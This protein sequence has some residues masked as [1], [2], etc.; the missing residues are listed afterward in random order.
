MRHGGLAAG[1]TGHR[2][3]FRGPPRCLGYGVLL[4]QHGPHLPDAGPGRVQLATDDDEM[5]AEFLKVLLEPLLLELRWMPR[6]LELL[7]LELI[8]LTLGFRDATPELL[9]VARQ[10]VTLVVQLTEAGGQ[11]VDSPGQFLR[12]SG[13]RHGLRDAPTI[14]AEPGHWPTLAP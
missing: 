6:E 13:F 2:E 14:A 4:D 12:R 11:P 9:D 5:G 3:G 1:R 10:A 7:E 8:Q